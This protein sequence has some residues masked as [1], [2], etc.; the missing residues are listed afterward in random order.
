VGALFSGCGNHDQPPAVSRLA[1]DGP[2]PETLKAPFNESAAK[3]T[4]QEWAKYIN[5]D[6]VEKNSLGQKLV[7]IP[8]GEFMMGSPE[9]EKF[10]VDD[11]Q[12][13]RV[14]ITRPFYMGMYAVTQAEYERFIGKNPSEFSAT[15]NF[16]KKVAT[17]DTSRFPVENVSSDEAVEFCR[18]LSAKEGKTYRLPT[19]AEWEYSCRA[20]TKTTFIFG[21]SLNT[22]EANWNGGLPYDTEVTGTFL[23]RPTAVGSYPPNAW[24]LYDMHGNVWQWCQDWFD[25]K[26]YDDSAAE[27]P[28]GPANGLRRVIRCGSWDGGAV[29]CRS[30]YRSYDEPTVRNANLG[31]RLLCEG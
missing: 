6:V 20:G 1:G 31:F 21:D 9:T 2:S 13:H 30:A 14:K 25:E 10:R 19:E 23:I 24:G 7:L 27:D 17:L 28:Q 26:Y 11:E 15:G 16:K 18:K 22:D 8:P 3:R 29:G 12:Q 5:R 4:Q